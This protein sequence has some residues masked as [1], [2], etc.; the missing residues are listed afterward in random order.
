MGEPKAPP[1]KTL[2]QAEM[3]LMVE[4]FRRLSQWRRDLKQKRVVRLVKGR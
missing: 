2:T 4:A 1:A 3:D